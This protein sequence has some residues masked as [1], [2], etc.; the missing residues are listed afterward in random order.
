M[1]SF[2]EGIIPPPSNKDDDGSN[3]TGCRQFAVKVSPLLPWATFTAAQG[4]KAVRATVERV[5]VAATV[6][7]PS[8]NPVWDPK[9]TS[10]EVSVTTNTGRLGSPRSV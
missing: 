6:T 10:V 9:S 1:N 4:V 7:R 3:P 8:S 5:T 2:L